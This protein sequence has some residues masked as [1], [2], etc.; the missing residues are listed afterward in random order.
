MILRAQKVGPGVYKSRRLTMNTAITTAQESCALTSQPQS[1]ADGSTPAKSKT[2]NCSPGT[3]C[4][5]N[6]GSFDSS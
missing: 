1:Q 6:V 3:P 5:A 2:R 4:A